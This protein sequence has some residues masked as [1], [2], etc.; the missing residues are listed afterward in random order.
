MAYKYSTAQERELR[1]V[2]VHNLETARAFGEKHDIP[3]RSVT[4][5]I[6]ALGLT[7][8][9]KGKTAAK[10]TGAISGARN[11]NKEQLVESVT[12]ILGIRLPSLRSMTNT[13]L[14]ELEKHLLTLARG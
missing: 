12:T 7:Y 11:R 9:T 1:E 10:S 2:G 5:K 8:E 6:K 13:D 4:A 3:V 14:E